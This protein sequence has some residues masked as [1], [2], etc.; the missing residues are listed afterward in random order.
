M[1]PVKTQLADRQIN[2]TIHI[3]GINDRY[4]RPEH[5]CQWYRKI[6][7]LFIYFFF[8]IDNMNCLRSKFNSIL[9]IIIVKLKTKI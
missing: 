4:G 6:Y 9:I 5:A 8:Q 1:V 2:Y 7:Y 3:V